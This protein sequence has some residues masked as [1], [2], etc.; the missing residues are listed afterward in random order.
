MTSCRLS[1]NRETY[2]EAFFRKIVDALSE[3]GKNYE[4]AVFPNCF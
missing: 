1:Q 4:E 2:I 3:K